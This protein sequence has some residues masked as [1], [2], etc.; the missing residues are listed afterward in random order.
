MSAQTR[1]LISELK[2]ITARER[3]FIFN[4]MGSKT[5]NRSIDERNFNFDLELYKYK[6]QMRLKRL[7]DLMY[8]LTE[9][10]LKKLAKVMRI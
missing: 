3:N 8:D 5:G 4:F 10:E 1:R 9:N 7:F 6:N 2:K